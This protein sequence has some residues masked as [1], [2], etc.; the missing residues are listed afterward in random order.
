MA[1]VI[2]TQLASRLSPENLSEL[3]DDPASGLGPGP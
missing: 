3:M 1:L 2:T